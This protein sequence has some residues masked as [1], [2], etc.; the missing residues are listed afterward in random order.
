MTGA[1]T[2]SQVGF[3]H[4]TKEAVQETMSSPAYADLDTTG[5]TT[6]YGGLGAPSGPTSVTV[7]V[8]G[9]PGTPPDDLASD[10]ESEVERR[11]DRDVAVAVDYRSSRTV[12]ASSG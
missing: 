6:E 1:L 4:Q 11:T 8:S 10:L 5:V 12:D 7:A 3:S 9:P 2:A